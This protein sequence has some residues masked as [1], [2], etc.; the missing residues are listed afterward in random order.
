M[1]AIRIAIGSVKIATSAE[2][3][4]SR[5]T[6]QTSATTTLSSTSFSSSVS[7]D[8]SISPERSYAV[9]IWTSAGSPGFSSASFALT[10]W[11]TS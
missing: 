4:C 7:T 11:M 1:N 10:R 2:R 8:R 5:N 9:T 6:R 3:T